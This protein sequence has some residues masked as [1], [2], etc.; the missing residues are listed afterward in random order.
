MGVLLE[1]FETPFE[2]IPFDKINQQDFVKDTETAIK[3]AKDRIE[4]I[5]QVPEVNFESVI[6]ALDKVSDELDI[7]AGTFFNLVS[8]HTNDDLQEMAKKISPMLSSYSND[9][10]LDADLFSKIQEVYEKKDQLNLS[11][12]QMTLLEKEY[13]SFVRNGANLNDTDKKRLREIDTRLS[14]LKVSFGENVLKATNEFVLSVKDESKLEGLPDSAKQSA[15]ELAKSKGN[16]GEWHFTLHFPSYIPVMQYMKD[17]SLRQ[18]MYQAKVNLCT[19]GTYDNKNNVDEIAKLR[20]ERANLLGYKTH[21]DYVLEERMA[22]SAKNVEDFLVNLKKH[23]WPAFERDVNDLKQYAKELDGIDDF[24]SWD[25]SY[26]SEKL[27]QK[28]LDFDDEVLR[29]YF[30]LENVINGVFDVASTLYGIK[31]VENKSIPTY[32]QDVTAYEVYDKDTNDFVG[33]FYTDF[34]PRESKSSGAWMTGFKSQYKEN[35]ADHRPHVAIV[36]NFTKPIGGKPSLLT[37]N[38]VLTLFH[39]FGHSLHGL[40]SKCEYRGLSGTNVH[41]DFV[42]LPSQIMENWV[43]EKECLDIF[44][45]HYETDEKISQEMIDKIKKSQQF[46]EGYATIRQLSFAYLDLAWH[47]VDPNKINTSV[48]EYEQSIMKDYKL[49]PMIE[50]ESMSCSFSHIFNGG[51]S[52]GYYSYKWAEVLDADAFEYFQEKGVFNTE[53]S[54]KFR[55]NILA[56]GGSIDPSKLYQN[57]R[58][59]APEDKA[60]LKRAGLTA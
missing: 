26:Y 39:E 55:D 22:K 31:F 47:G 3:L 21:A 51:Y 33:V 35:G 25:F 18:Q 4:K 23:A 44:A 24:Q 15:Q 40:L 19:S 43:Y 9:V 2:T 34:F 56:K 13:K 60:L 10:I 16:E 1:K 17:R 11:E 5:K 30:K 52:A 58:G 29:P 54:Y 45:R 32:H 12:E 38:E 36:C 14:Q 20:F 27:K 53:V 50:N 48:V 6:E 41:W 59:R 7:V 46:M 28:V 37:L 57:F 8:A 49:F 42:E